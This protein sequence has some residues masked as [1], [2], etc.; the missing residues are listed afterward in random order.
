MRADRK[1][2]ANIKSS[3]DILK[4]IL[5]SHKYKVSDQPSIM[6]ASVLL[7]ENLL[8]NLIKLQEKNTQLISEMKILKN[9]K[10]KD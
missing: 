9:E 6:N 7:V 5:I 10:H 1:R 4:S 8:S 2:R 3:M